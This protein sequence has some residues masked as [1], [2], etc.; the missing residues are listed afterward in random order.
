MAFVKGAPESV[1]E[2]CTHVYEGKAV[3]LLESKD[4][5][6]IME[7]YRAMAQDA[8]RVLA[9]AEKIFEDKSCNEYTTFCVEQEL[10]FVGLMGMMDPPR[11]EV[12]DAIATCK[13]AGIKTVMITGDNKITATA[14]GKTVGIIDDGDVLEGDQ[15][16]K[17]NDEELGIAA[18]S[19]SIYA[20]AAPAHKLRIVDALKRN[21]HV[22]AMTG[23]GVNDA[24]ALKK[25]DI[26]VAMGI[27]GTDVVRDFPGLVFRGV[28]DRTIILN[29][30]GITKPVVDLPGCPPKPE[31][32]LALLV[33]LLLDKLQFPEDSCMLDKYLRFKMIK[34]G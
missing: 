17:M 26:G 20:H 16:E 23:D 25:A 10:V 34:G 13:S 32:I 18:R 3:R 6:N 33:L 31:H 1:L 2:L 24:P 8:L 22:V 21:G 5:D 11:E 19:V 7:A 4:R 27:T 30:H 9:F 15:I 12:I 28:A 14:V 29:E